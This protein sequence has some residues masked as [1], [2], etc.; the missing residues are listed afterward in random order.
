[1]AFFPSDLD[2]CHLDFYTI[3]V[4]AVEDAQLLPDEVTTLPTIL[5]YKDGKLQD[6]VQIGQ[7]RPARALAQGIKR[8]FG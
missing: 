3:D 1:M 7:T 2:F 4:D 6:C 5:L 8:V